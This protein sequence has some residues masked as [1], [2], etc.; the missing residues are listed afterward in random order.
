M[1]LILSAQG[2]KCEAE[3]LFDRA[4]TLVREVESPYFLCEYLHHSADL[5]AGQEG[6][7][8]ATV[9]NDEA[10]EIAKTVDRRDVRLPAELLSVRLRR[11]V[12]SIEQE[13]A[14]AELERLAAEWAEPAEQAAVQFELW[15]LNGSEG[16]RRSAA[17][18]Y[19]TLH[20]AT[21]NVVYRERY[22][23]LTGDRLPAP[24]P[25][26]PLLDDR[27]NEVDVPALLRRIEGVFR[28]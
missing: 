14:E 16:T 9:R 18:L 19:S 15:L 11:A 8:E 5:L 10:L 2:R 7:A 12:E 21:P 20:A 3:G 6:W 27:E 24:A 23:S 4:I 25:L 22:E 26:P 28:D 1:A 13:H 17:E